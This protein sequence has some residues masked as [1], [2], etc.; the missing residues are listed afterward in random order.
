MYSMS[1]F[2]HVRQEVPITNISVADEGTA[3]C[4]D[5]PFVYG[6]SEFGCRACDHVQPWEAAIPA[7]LNSISEESPSIMRKIDRKQSPSTNLRVSHRRLFPSL[8]PV[9]LH[10]RFLHLSGFRQNSGQPPR[11]LSRRPNSPSCGG[12]GLWRPQFVDSG[13]R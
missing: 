8:L 12:F 9:N 2:F 1:C 4:E 6:W 11:R 5:F 10:L 13:L 7:V 3:G